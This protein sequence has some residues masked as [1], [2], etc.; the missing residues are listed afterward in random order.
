MAQLLIDHR[1]TI[2]AAESCTGGLLAERLTRIPGSSNYFLGGVVCYSNEMKTAWADVPAELI[3]A[4]GA[5]SSEVAIALGGRHSPAC[6]K[7]CWAWA[8]RESPGRAAAAR[9]NRSAPC[10]SR[11]PGLAGVKEK[12]VHLPGDREAIRFYAS[13]L[14]LDMV[15]MHF[16]YSTHAQPRRVSNS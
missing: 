13:Q 12:L 3:A 16:L 6:G 11:W 7:H 15:R 1:A 4:K 9:K 5:V 8:S 2:A 14:G 10:T